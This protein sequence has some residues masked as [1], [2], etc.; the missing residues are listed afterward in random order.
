MA[1][2][3]TSLI[4]KEVAHDLLGTT[5]T[6]RTFLFDTSKVTEDQKRAY[7]RVLQGHIAVDQAVFPKGST[8]GAQIGDV[9]LYR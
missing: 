6:T 5:D 2:A 8:T 9:P 3:L 7:T 1:S 4:R